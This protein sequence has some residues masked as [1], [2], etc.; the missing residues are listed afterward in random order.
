MY[1]NVGGQSENS[2]MDAIGYSI[3]ELSQC[4]EYD[5]KIGDFYNTLMDIDAICSDL[6]REVSGY[7]EEMTFDEER[8]EF[9]SERLDTI[10]KLKMKYGATIELINKK[11]DELKK[12]YSLLKNADEQLKL[13]KEKIAEAEE[14][15]NR[16]ST[17]LSEKR[18]NQA[19]ILE[20]NIT[21]ALLDLN[22]N[23]VRFS[24]NFE[25]NPTYSAKGKDIVEFYISLN[26]GEKLRPLSQIASGGELSRIMLALKSV[27]AGKDEMET[28][29][30]DEIDTG[31]SGRT[32]QKVSE[33]MKLISRDRQV[34]A[35]THLPQIAAMADTHFLIEK[36]SENG[37]T[38]TGI[39][40]VEEKNKVLELERMLGGKEITEK[41]IENAEEMKKIAKI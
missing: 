38:K 14:K 9:V 40:E 18:K 7:I 12:R 28:L 3:K 1:E 13:M 29:I 4:L 31:I 41:V 32:A 6:S 15:L 33:K 27:M 36:T 20:K 24:V 10:N 17:K 8:V 11:L 21:D 25:E 34:I 5:E 35:I 16:D 26:P 39:R 19:K 37:I 2:F 22:F 30:F 23:D